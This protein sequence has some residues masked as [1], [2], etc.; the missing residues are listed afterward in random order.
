MRLWGFDGQDC[1]WL[2]WGYAWFK[3]SIPY[4]F[5]VHGIAVDRMRERMLRRHNDEPMAFLRRVF[6]EHLSAI[7]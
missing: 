7:Y 1:C 4:W 3:S 2:L 5:G 6:R